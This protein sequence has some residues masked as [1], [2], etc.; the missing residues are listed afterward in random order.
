M[1]EKEITPERLS[2]LEM[3]EGLVNDPETRG[4]YFA[5]M[6]KK[7]PGIAIPEVDVRTQMEAL[8][9]QEREKREKLEQDIKDERT[10]NQVREARANALKTT[11]LTD[12][13]MPEI[14]KVMT[15]QGILNHETA[16]RYVKQSRELAAGSTRDVPPAPP[17]MP[18]PRDEAKEKFGGD[19]KAWSRAA[20]LQAFRENKKAA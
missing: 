9:A 5:L 1:S 10:R 7:N 20:M 11:G 18:N 3:A 2:F 15:E 13:D 4:A 16:A 12:A 17:A 6:K 19:L 14:E 8:V